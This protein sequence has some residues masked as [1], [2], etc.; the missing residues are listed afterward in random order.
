[1]NSGYTTVE[2]FVLDPTFQSW[3][4]R[5]ERGSNLKWETF[6]LNNPEKS[7]LVKEAR[8][9][10]VA[11]EDIK[12]VSKDTSLSFQAKE[13]LWKE[14]R[15][16]LP[17]TEHDNIAEI[18]NLK[19]G[20]QSQNS[21]NLFLKS[22][23]KI[24]YY[25]AAACVLVFMILGGVY[26]SSIENHKSD[27]YA[28]NV[29][30]TNSTPPGTKSSSKLPDG[31][32]VFLNAGSSIRFRE[33]LAGN[34]REIFLEGEAFFEVAKDSIRPFLVHSGN[35]TTQA[36]GTSFNIRNFKEKP[37]E[38]AL[39]TGKIKVESQDHTF[40]QIL[41][42]GEGVS[43]SGGIPVKSQVDVNNSIA[44]MNKTIVFESEG[45]LEAIEELENWFGVDISITNLP[46]NPST[47]SAKYI[48]ESLE[49]ILIG[50]GYKMDFDYEIDGSQ[51]QIHF[52]PQK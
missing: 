24:Y 21:K 15:N 2:D 37:V 23:G 47:I 11:L 26:F 9:F 8:E 49:N 38:I 34:I 14:I 25:L 12:S 39:L 45:F 27:R 7:A 3:V 29:W 4:L 50:L 13:R 20:Y 41:I 1:M 35:L 6:L 36:L 33:G 22:T 30:L 32:V 48:N 51:V 10:L 18:P 43:E 5:N 19:N 52:K 42:P 46:Q 16:S 40:Y 31:T 44:W 17:K 28:E